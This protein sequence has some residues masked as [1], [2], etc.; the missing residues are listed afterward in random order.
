MSKSNVTLGMMTW[1]CGHGHIQETIKSILNQT[2]KEFTL[3]IF[4]DCSPQDPTQYIHEII[5]N[6]SRVIYYRSKKRLGMCKASQTV[7]NMSC[8]DTEY[9]A[10]ISDHDVYNILWLER[11]MALM[12][13]NNNAA[14]AYPFIEG[15]D[16]DGKNNDR[17]ST[18]Y[19]NSQESIYNRLNSFSRLGAGS[20][21]IIYGLFRYAIIKK[22]GGWPTLI[23]PD[24]IL[25]YEVNC[26]GS[27]NQC[28]EYLIKRRDQK[29]RVGSGVNLVLRQINGIY[30]NNR[31]LYSYFNYKIVNCIYLLYHI[32]LILDGKKIYRYKY[33]LCASYLYMK[34]LYVPKIKNTIRTLQRIE[35]Q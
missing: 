28:P 7:L 18:V 13:Q 2:Y 22:I 31:P 4:D 19:D 34:G 23:T 11:L 35:Q 3:I 1:M 30:P 6:D 15:I 16:N 20:G 8:V 5:R 26:F 33:A 24:V 14:V 17:K 25:L 29:E 27:I 12:I 32:P 21:N 9:F 10:W